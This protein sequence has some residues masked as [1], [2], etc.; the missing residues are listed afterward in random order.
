[1]AAQ[2][3]VHARS[4]DGHHLQVQHTSTDSPILPA[5]NLRQLQQIDPSLVSWVVS[6]TEQEATHRR[7]EETRINWFIL[8][9]RMAGIIAGTI[10]AIFGLGLAGYLVLQGHDWAGVGLGGVSLGTIVSVL[11]ARNHKKPTSNEDPKK[12]PVK[13][14]RSKPKAS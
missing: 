8:I 6:Q 4:S 14:A 10:V 9:E 2:T 3:N 11:V 7:R 12:T 5:E 13:R 1:M